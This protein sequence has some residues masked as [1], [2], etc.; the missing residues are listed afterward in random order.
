M[1]RVFCKSCG[2]AFIATIVIA[3]PQKTTVSIPLYCPICGIKNEYAAADFA[4]ANLQRI[5]AESA[6]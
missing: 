4:Q 2:V 3:E 5:K 1:W 6:S